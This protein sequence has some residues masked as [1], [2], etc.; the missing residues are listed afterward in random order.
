MRCMQTCS[1][2]GKPGY[3]GY[4]EGRREGIIIKTGNISFQLDYILETFMARKKHGSCRADPA[5]TLCNYI[6]HTTPYYNCFSGDVTI[7]LDGSGV[8]RI[9]IL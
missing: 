8:V 6:S 5:L 3:A 4:A 9:G 7:F 1:V 2:E